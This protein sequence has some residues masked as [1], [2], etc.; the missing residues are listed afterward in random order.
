MQMH[1]NVPRAVAPDYD[2]IP[3]STVQAVR[4]NKGVSLHK[5]C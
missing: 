4:R 2:I 3:E 1:V 5:L